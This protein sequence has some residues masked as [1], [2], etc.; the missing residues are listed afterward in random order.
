M[1]YNFFSLL[2]EYLN[3]AKTVDDHEAMMKL[4]S[5]YFALISSAEQRPDKEAMLF[6]EGLFSVMSE[7]ALQKERLRDIAPNK[8]ELSDTEQEENTKVQTILDRNMFSYHFQPIVRADSGEIYSYEALMRANGFPG[9]SPLHILKYA[10]LTGRLDEVEKYTFLNVLRFID[11]HRELFNDRLVFINSMPK[12]RL[13]DETQSEIEKLFNKLSDNVVVEM[14][15]S[16]EYGDNELNDIKQKFLRLN[17]PIAIDDYGTG[18]SNISNLLRYTPN[19]VKID[20][21]LLSGIQHNP[22]K[23]HFVREIVDFCH[24]NGILALAEG[25]ENS[26]ELR[27]VILLG[28]DLIQGFY[29]ARPSAEIITAL[30]YSVRSEIK[31]YHLE[32]EDGIRL[33]IYTAE[34]GEKVSLNKLSRDGYNCLRVGDG[35][36]EGSVTVAGSQLIDSGVHIEIADNFKGEVTLDSA[37]LYNLVERP[38]IDISFDSDVTL[39]L[40]GSSKLKNSGIRVPPSSKLTLIGEG[41]LTIEPGSADYYGIGNDNKSAHGDLFFMQDGTITISAES[42]AG[43]LIGSG[44]GGVIRIGRGRYVL[45]ANGSLNICIGAI[46]GD[47][48]IELL[49]CDLECTATGAYSVVIGSSYGCAD[50]HAIYSSI[51]CSSDS[52]LAVTM[53]SIAGDQVKVS[54]ESVN[55]NFEI[56]A[57]ACTAFGALYKSS[58]ISIE[59]ASVNVTA[60]GAKALLFGGVNGNTKIALTNADFSASL[61]SE[62]DTYIIAENSDIQKSGGK[63]RINVNNTEQDVT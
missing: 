43:V 21:S 18:Y 22:N 14:I 20:R 58:D 44:L 19:Y 24:D 55:M 36:S 62:L 49:G 11:S 32:R 45:N 60:E 13:D 38:C 52:Q 46:D 3:K 47:T 57:D 63:Y 37:W 40:K 51:K 41:N 34:N 10:E 26:E 35:Y 29:T 27:T 54:T 48:D 50:I 61:L 12:V 56:S 28:V 31:S 23:K 59:R 30:P 8:D 7:Y 9:I 33:K 5:E 1:K 53:G 2:G 16:S 42:H 15:E 17:I 6:A 25:V 39:R 4:N